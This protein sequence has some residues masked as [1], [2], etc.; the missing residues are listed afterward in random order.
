MRAR[1]L[2]AAF[3]VAVVLLLALGARS[4]RERDEPAPARTDPV[5]APGRI[6]SSAPSPRDDTQP[7]AVAARTTARQPLPDASLPLRETFAELDAQAR[8]G[9]AAAAC[10]LALELDTCAIAIDTA[11]ISTPLRR[12]LELIATSSW[13][14]AQKDAH[15][16]RAQREAAQLD[17]R[18]RHCEGI[19][20]AQ[21][22]PS[23]RYL[24]I[25]ARAG[26]A[27]SRLMYLNSIGLTPSA[28]LRDPGL[29]TD[30]RLTAPLLFRQAI[31]EG[32]ASVLLPWFIA[33]AN[34]DATPLAVVLPEEFRR[35]GVVRA[36]H[37]LLM[38]AGR[39]DVPP[40][41][42]RMGAP[43]EPPSP[44]DAQAAQTLFDAHFRTSPDRGPIDLASYLGGEGAYR[45]EE[46]AER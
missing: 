21:Q 45:C 20:P 16:A 1:A 9:H 12:R 3:V 42:E 44:E 32:D 22:P 31:D 33:V 41:T 2:V 27:P 46:L 18:L 10:R 37:A 24:A 17:D 4:M 35:P 39:R 25:A 26:H 28:M 30:Y 14:R 11:R 5:S 23:V 43:A 15:I 8:A 36:L 19:D 13:P 6:E 38:D 34:P 40:L 29:G 7:R